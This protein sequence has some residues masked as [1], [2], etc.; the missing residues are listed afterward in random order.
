[1]TCV[2]S[3]FP[4]RGAASDGSAG[5]GPCTMPPKRGV[6][7][8]PKIVTPAAGKNVPRAQAQAAASSRAQA[9]RAAMAQQQTADEAEFDAGWVPQA[10]PV[11]AST[12]P[13]RK[14]SSGRGSTYPGRN[15]D[16]YADGWR[17]EGEG[18]PQQRRHQDSVASASLA[19]ALASVPHPT[20]DG[21]RGSSAVL[22]GCAAVAVLL[23]G[24]VWCWLASSPEMV[25]SSA[26]NR[27]AAIHEASETQPV[28]L[29][30]GTPYAN[31]AGWGWTPTVFT[32]LLL[33]TSTLLW[34][35][36]RRRAANKRAAEQQ[37]QQQQQAEVQR[38]EEQAKAILAEAKASA[39]QA[40]EQADEAARERQAEV[41]RAQ[42]RAQ[43]ILAEAEAFARL[44]KEQAATQASARLAREEQAAEQAAHQRL[45]AEEEAVAA[46]A[47][48]RERQADEAA[49]ERQAEVARAQE[50]AQAILAEAAEQAAHQRLLA[51][52]EAVAA[53]AA[54]RE[55]QVEI[56]RVEERAKT[57][58]A[59][60]R[61]AKE[62]AKQ[63]AAQT[64]RLAEEEA[65]ATMAESEQRVKSTESEAEEGTPPA[66][67]QPEAAGVQGLS[68]EACP[69][70]TT[71]SVREQHTP[72]RSHRLDAA[73]PTTP[74]AKEEEDDED[75]LL[76]RAGSTPKATL[77]AR[78]KEM[79]VSELKKTAIVAGVD[80]DS[81]YSIADAVD[82]Q[83]TAIQLIL[84]A[85][86]PQSLVEDL[87]QMKTS[88]LVR[89]AEGDGVDKATLEQIDDAANSRAAAI[90]AIVDNDMRRRLHP[91]LLEL[92][93]P[94]AQPEPEG[95]GYGFTSRTSSGVPGTDGPGS[96]LTPRSAKIEFLTGAALKRAAF[97][98]YSRRHA[99]ALNATNIMVTALRTR[100]KEADGIPFSQACYCKDIVLW[101]DKEQMGQEGGGDWSRILARAQKR[102]FVNLFF[103]SNAYSG[104]DECLKELQFA[105]M[106]KMP[107]IPI[108]LEPYIQDEE[109]FQQKNVARLC[110][111]DMKTFEGFE[112]VQDTVERLCNRLQGVPAFW[113]L[114]KFTCNECRT[115]R[116]FVCPRCTDWERVMKS[117][118]ATQMVEAVTSLGRYVDTAARRAGLKITPLAELPAEGAPNSESKP[119]VS[120]APAASSLGKEN[121]F[122]SFVA[123]TVKALEEAFRHG[124]DRVIIAGIKGDLQKGQFTLKEWPEM[125]GYVQ[126]AIEGGRV[127]GATWEQIEE[128][129]K[130]IGNLPEL[131]DTAKDATH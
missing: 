105:D 128:Q 38:A 25:G 120:A 117:P 5:R 83:T 33:V 124:A 104:S 127:K 21:E 99:G 49:R 69:P 37:Q 123:Q 64:R 72:T 87:G 74:E 97:V 107:R 91:E 109:Q 35:A 85:A 15:D 92:L 30:L 50:R 131:V 41:A 113:D 77:W 67:G 13:P 94:Q 101:M 26:I 102:S 58:L 78:L 14:K 76:A 98:S 56:T 55:R 79:K 110:D 10:R 53:A 71:T 106:K 82:P 32:T 17:D 46:A 27:T 108:F 31:Q 43:A 86:S 119:S 130:D 24:A 16:A 20:S 23:G 28:A 57:M 8:S 4:R 84:E 103:L 118:V 45:L 63:E 121:W 125:L 61:L 52:E 2:V 95:A 129:R 9:A 90:D 96:A 89:R 111:A 12:P 60:A 34:I 42:E 7:R 47:A 100:R 75:D 66:Q 3:W 11:T 68:V 73:S 59:S 88:D 18:P 126:K 112:D 1:M 93:N 40:Q 115:K 48:A 39:E 19:P 81:R 36:L 62:Q 54:A 80:D 22:T 70:E 116:D 114:S 44:T 65:A 29:H 6:P 122:Q 51:E